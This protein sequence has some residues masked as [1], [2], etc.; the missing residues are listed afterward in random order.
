MK[1]ILSLLLIL[2]LAVGIFVGCG[3][4]KDGVEAAKEMTTQEV[5][6]KVQE[7]SQ[8]MTNTSFLADFDLE[9][10]GLEEM[11]LAGPMGLT[12]TGDIK[13]AENM[14]MTMDIDTGMGMEIKGDIYLTDNTILIHAPLLQQFMGY[15][16]LK[17]DLET[18]AE[19]AGTPITQ[20]DPEKVKAILERFEESTEYSIYDIVKLDDAK[21]TVE[22]VVN[23][24]TVD[25]TKLT[26]NVD[27]TGADD[28]IF[29]F[30]DFIINDEEAKELFLGTMT[31]ED[32]TLMQEEMANEESRA[33]LKKA[34]EA[35]TINEFSIVIYANADYQTIKTEFVADLSFVDPDL[36]QE[37][38]MKLTGFMEYFNI[39]GV[40]E[41]VLPEVDPSEILDMNEM[42]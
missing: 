21:E 41:I 20:P 34:L 10:T 29:A 11:G 25:A 16:Y 26:M 30:V 24:E 42:Y 15:A 28:V 39:G 19:Q 12:M 18:L 40:E 1:K 33:E 38:S 3:G 31:E 5:F 27:L 22:V 8:E 13:D 2:T 37:F 23:E 7:V 36:G 4:D 32:I 6:E 35:I 17:A 9:M 14:K